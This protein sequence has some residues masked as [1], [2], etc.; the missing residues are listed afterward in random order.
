MT[1]Q[2]SHDLLQIDTLRHVN[3]LGHGQRQTDD[4]LVHVTYADGRT[5]KEYVRPGMAEYLLARYPVERFRQNPKAAYAKVVV[6]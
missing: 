5:V 3:R 4:V 1:E 6:A 2:T